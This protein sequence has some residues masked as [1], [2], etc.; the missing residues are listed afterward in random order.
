MSLPSEYLWK[1]LTYWSCQCLIAPPPSSC[2]WPKYGKIF[3]AD[4]TTSHVLNSRVT[5]PNLTKISHK[6][7]LAFENELEYWNSDFRVFIGHQF[8][9]PINTL[10]SEFQYSNS[11]SNASM[12]N[13]WWSS[14]WTPVAAQFPFVSLFFAKTTGPI[15]AKSLHDIVALVALLNHAYI[16]R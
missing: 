13:G 4:C 15:V 6:V 10:K 9:W 16:R 7:I 12:T 14:N 8:W 2:S 3:D 11:F 1:T 5:E